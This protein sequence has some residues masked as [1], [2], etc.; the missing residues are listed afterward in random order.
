M[1]VSNGQPREKDSAYSELTIKVESGLV[2][3]IAIQSLAYFDSKIL[4]PDQHFAPNQAES[5]VQSVAE[6]RGAWQIK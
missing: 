4:L 1:R 5:E 2:K 6:A 3:F